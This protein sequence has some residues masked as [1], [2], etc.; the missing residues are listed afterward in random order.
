MIKLQV[1]K[2][3]MEHEEGMNH[4]MV[5]IAPKKNDVKIEKPVAFIL[6]VDVSGSMDS[7]AENESLPTNINHSTRFFEK[8]ATKLDFVKG[9]AEKLLDMMKNGDHLGVISF[10]DFAKIEYPLEELSNANRMKIKDRIRSLRTEGCTNVSDGIHTAYQ[11]ITSSLKESHHIKMILL[12]DGEANRGV[13][14]IDKLSTLVSNY[15]KDHL[16]ISTIGVGVHYN[17]YFMENIATSSGGMFY[18]LSAMDQLESI[19]KDELTTLATLTTKQAKLTLSS[20]SGFHF[21]K[22]LNDFSETTA[23]EI[24]LGNVFSEQILLF[25]FSTKTKV[26]IGD[27]PIT[28]TLEYMDEDNRLSIQS[29][30]IAVHVTDEEEL[31][32]LILNEDVL[33][34]VKELMAAKTKKESLR[35]Y[36]S[37]DFNTLSSTMGGHFNSASLMNATYGEH[38]ISETD[39]SEIKSLETQM[40]SKSLNASQTKQ[41]YD[42]SYRSLRNE[43]S[44]K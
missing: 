22:N 21:E 20:P 37:G 13:T 15:R 16:S 7:P 5:N 9:A 18:H 35:S 41:L 8:T 11:Q 39:L 1:A 26:A 34:K 25:E 6:C 44:S 12:S 4:L 27:Y 33:S 2:N 23:Q 43:S 30:Q 38:F 40:M 36:E 32:N 14:D 29:Q 10:S 3:K 24:F 17:S 31:S 42:S 19:L 28:A